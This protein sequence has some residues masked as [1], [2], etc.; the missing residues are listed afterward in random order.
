MPNRDED[1]RELERGAQEEWI[2]WLPD[3]QDP[4]TDEGEEE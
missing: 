2:P 4:F 3:N 1:L